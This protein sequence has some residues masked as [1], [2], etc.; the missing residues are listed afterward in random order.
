MTMPTVPAPPKSD[1]PTN[2]RL[3]VL[4]I[5]GTIAGPSNTV[6]QPV[7]DAIKTVQAQGI[8]VAIATGRMFRS[9]RRFHQMVGST[10]PLMAYQGAWIQDPA[11]PTPERHWSVPQ[12]LIAE[13]LDFLEQPAW[14]KALSVHCYLNDQ[15]YVRTLTPVSQAY[16]E[17]SG[18]EPHA[19]GDL[20]DL[21]A[22]PTKLLALGDS[23]DLIQQLLVALQRRYS[24]TE[25]YLTT[26]VETFL[27]ATN[28]DANKGNA[29]RY[30]AE[31][32]LGLQPENVMAIGDNFNDVEM[33]QYAGIGVAMGDAPDPVKAVAQWVAPSVEADGVVAAI[34][35]FLL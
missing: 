15:L 20:R 3:L 34:A 19:I 33:L 25:L 6:R 21:P 27:E 14:G 31:E 13:L 1:R 8:K 5:D 11:S 35:R 16:A 26:S 12:P 30:V 18:I 29:V 4:D 9:A 23:A 28:P 24:P 10:L 2:I 7:I 17:R 22:A 32:L